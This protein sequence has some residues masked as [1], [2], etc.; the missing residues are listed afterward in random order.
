MI[1]I[2]ILD[3]MKININILIYIYIEMR[4]NNTIMNNI[5]DK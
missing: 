2:M 4:I 3:K 1:D 5:F